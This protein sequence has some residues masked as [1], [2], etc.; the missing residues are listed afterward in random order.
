MSHAQQLHNR[1]YLDGYM[2]IINR[3]GLPDNVKAKVSQQVRAT[4]LAT[5]QWTIEQALEEEVTAYVGCPRYAHLPRGRP[6]E[7]TRSPSYQAGALLTQYGRIPDLRVPKLRRGSSALL[8][9]PITRYERCWG[10][11]ARPTG[12]GLL[13][14]A[15]SAGPPGSD[16]LDAGEDAV[17]GRPVPGSCLGW[18]TRVAAWKTGRLAAPPPI[19][20]V[21]G[22]WVKIAYPSGEVRV[23]QLGRRRAVKRKQNALSRGPRRVARWPLGDCALED[24]RPRRHGGLE[25]LHRR[26]LSEKGSPK[27]RPQLVVC[28]GT[29]G[30]FHGAGAAPPVCSAPTVSVPTRSR[31][32][33]ITYAIRTSHGANAAPRRSGP[34]G[35]TGPQKSHLSGC[36]A[37]I[38][39]G[40]RTECG[41]GRGLSR[42]VGP[43]GTPGRG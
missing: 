22:C 5:V 40:C 24:F 36:G 42:H 21:D 35:E 6:A 19:V 41:P 27:K 4:V 34:P 8:S 38:Q 20:I 26:T 7:Y 43:A 14:G 3:A 31:I 39:L 29:E 30:A 9:R 12:G 25:C 18:K 15:R 16:A 37:G 13:L 2:Q 32:S 10:A 28:D 11:P 17:A 23:D 33:P 1:R